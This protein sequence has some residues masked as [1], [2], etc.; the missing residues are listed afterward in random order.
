MYNN[1]W[2]DIN[3]IA[4]YLLGVHISYK[5]NGF[6]YAGVSCCIYAACGLFDLIIRNVKMT[7]LQ[8]YIYVKKLQLSVHL[9][10]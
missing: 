7:F 10:R 3:Q 9:E 4:N 5:I 8:D 6:V 2:Q 1:K